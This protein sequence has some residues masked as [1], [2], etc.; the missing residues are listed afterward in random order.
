MLFNKFDWLYAIATL[1][2][3]LG[4]IRPAEGSALTTTIP[5][6]DRTCFYAWVDTQGEKASVYYKTIIMISITDSGKTRLGSISLLVFKSRSE[7]KFG[8][9]EPDAT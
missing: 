6:S 2:F 8:C 9:N 7:I 5:A 3:S 4:Q 1:L